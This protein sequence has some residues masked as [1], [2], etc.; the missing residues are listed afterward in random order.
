MNSND[1][2]HVPKVSDGI[3]DQIM[4]INGHPSGSMGQPSHLTCPT[5]EFGDEGGDM[6]AVGD[7]DRNSVTNRM[8]IDADASLGNKVDGNKYAND[9]GG[10]AC[11]LKVVRDDDSNSGINRMDIDADVG[12][13]KKFEGGRYS[14]DA[15]GKDCVLKAV[16][17]DENNSGINRIDIDAVRGSHRLDN[18]V[19][20][21]F[22]VQTFERLS[23]LDDGIDCSSSS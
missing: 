16:G 14:N 8:D 2:I 4:S 20:E 7:G 3:A 22:Y 21:I 17:N 12:L 5:G 6:K 13:E 9:A 10:K 18:D 1:G 11:D 23:I 19:T 15:G